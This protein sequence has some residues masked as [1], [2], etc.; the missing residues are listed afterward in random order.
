MVRIK[1]GSSRSGSFRRGKNNQQLGGGCLVMFFF[2]FF[3]VGAITFCFMFVAPVFHGMQATTWQETPCTIVSSEVETHHGDD[4]DSYSVRIVYNYDFDG[5]HF[6]SDRYHFMVG[7]TG[8]RSGKQAIVDRYPPGSKSICY[9]NPDDPTQAVIH[10][11]F[12]TDMLFGLFPLIFLAVGLGGMVFGVRA[13]LKKKAL[14]AAFDDVD[15]ADAEWLPKPSTVE[16]SD[17]LYGDFGDASSKGPVTLRSKSSPV[18]TLIA[19]VLV[20]LFWNGIVSIFL[21]FVVDGFRKGDPEWF[22]TVFLTPFVLIGLAMVFWVGHSFLA[23][24]NPRPTIT[25]SSASVPLGETME[26]TWRFSGN[27]GSIRRLHIYLQGQEE[28]QYRRGTKTHTDTEEFAELTV[29]DTHNFV[30]IPSGKV[31]V[32]IPDNTMHS[33]ES[34]NNKI[35][36]T[37]HVAGEI[38]WWPDVNVS[39]PLVILP[40]SIAETR[41]L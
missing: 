21:W 38:A 12:S 31:S 37:I 33:F 35:L 40:K 39:Y 3:A 16:N 4:S 6:E 23:I 13:M 27:T 10:R 14:P 29:T 18:G 36:W 8:G 32:T 41:K 20:C 34:P 15:E 2:I 22:L 5:R 17:S 19:A 26:L 11:G 24:F 9:V 1:F 7:S 28:S 30:D 25:I